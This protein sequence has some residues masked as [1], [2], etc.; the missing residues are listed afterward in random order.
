MYFATSVLF[1]QPGKR[2]RMTVVVTTLKY[3]TRRDYLQGWVKYVL[4]CWLIVATVAG[5][6]SLAD[7]DW[8]WP[9]RAETMETNPEELSTELV[10]TVPHSP[11][12]GARAG[13][14]SEGSHVKPHRLPNAPCY[15]LAAAR[16]DAVRLPDSF[17]LR[18]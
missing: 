15:R 14:A 1:T 5:S 3:I 11:R 17:R 16:P 4:L 2:G 8:I 10:L 9:W 12:R 13:L 7:N 18:C 6:R